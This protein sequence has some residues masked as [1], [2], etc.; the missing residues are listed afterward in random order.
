MEKASLQMEEEGFVFGKFD[1]HTHK[2][3]SKSY[4]VSGY[5]S[6]LLFTEHGR[7]KRKYEGGKTYDA[8]Q[9]WLY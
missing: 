9:M 5:P 8:V 3:I 4:D 2:E 6:I 1:G 7:K